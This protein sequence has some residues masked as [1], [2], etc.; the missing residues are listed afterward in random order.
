M[1][2]D[3]YTAG[4]ALDPQV[5]EMHVRVAL[6]QHVVQQGEGIPLV[7]TEMIA[8]DQIEGVTC[9]GLVLIVPGGS[10]QPRL[11]ATSC[12]VRPKR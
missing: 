8:G 4:R 1:H 5:G 12:A 10:Y 7:L 6:Q 11:S 3:P 9:L 2:C